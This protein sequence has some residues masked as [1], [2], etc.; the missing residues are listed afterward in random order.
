MYH[1]KNDK[2]SKNSARQI[3]DSLIVLL[4]QKD[5]DRISITETTS[6]ALV[7][8]STF[9]RNF[10]SLIDVLHWQCAVR[11]EEVMDRF[12]KNPNIKETDLIEYVFSYWQDNIDVLECLL[13]IKR[14]DIIYDC[15]AE[16]SKKIMKEIQDDNQITDI[17]FEYFTSIR[18][19]V[20]V[21]VIS[22]WIKCGK[23]EPARTISKII[24]AEIS[25]TKTTN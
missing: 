8:R 9:Y 2:R 6:S 1:I 5:F 13:K 22:T 14:I 19:G 12:K 20:F 25:F 11:F 24:E 23:K 18:V 15:F 21:G 3:F 10:D 17:E 4:K 7:G 16:N